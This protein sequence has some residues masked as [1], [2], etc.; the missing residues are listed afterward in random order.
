MALERPYWLL[1]GQAVLMQAC[2]FAVRPM[3]SY[4]ALGAGASTSDLGIIAAAFGVL[5]LLAA[6]PVGR[7][8]DR[9]GP[10]RMTICGVTVVLG[11]VSLAL[12]PAA[13]PTLVA[14]G[15]I[16]GLGHVMAM[17]GHQT[18]VAAR[19]PA[20]RRE[21][22][23]NGYS[24]FVSIGQAVGPPA[25][26]FVASHLA[27]SSGEVQGIDPL[28]GLIAAGA[29]AG[30]ALPAAISMR[31]R[32]HRPGPPPPV[33]PVAAE[34]RTAPAGSQWPVMTTSALVVASLDVLLTFLPAWA[35]SKG[36]APVVVGWLLAIRAASTL[37]IRTVAGPLVRRLG[38]LQVLA[39]SI[40]CACL[41]FAVLPFFGERVAFASMPLLGIGLG[42]AQ[43]LTLVMLMDRTDAGAHGAAVGLRLASNRLG[44]V[45][46]PLAMSG[47]AAASGVNFVWWGT[48]LLL[49]SCVILVLRQ[50]TYDA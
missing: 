24:S 35:Q 42:L 47:V 17:A 30:L 27:L 12:L 43:P 4:R 33:E 5:S 21:A 28:T 2:Y 48:A 6:I 23:T 37:L 14:A 1:M 13:V 18:L 20:S 36:I 39:A 11:G 9:I 22:V 49:S 46:L 31:E 26:L 41:G 38:R 3:V 15:A 32:R 10:G 40:C 44:Q 16:L 29:I 25:G 45:L 7:L 34:E 50:R 8:V 19:W